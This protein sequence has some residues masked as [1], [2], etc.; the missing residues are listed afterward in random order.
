MVGR[1]LS[2]TS[3][4]TSVWRGAYRQ[5]NDDV[6]A[7]IAQHCAHYTGKLVVAITGVATQEL[8]PL[9]VFGFPVESFRTG[10]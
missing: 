10:N 9:V 2:P 6:G 5:V 4:R 7:V 1:A 8:E 3:T